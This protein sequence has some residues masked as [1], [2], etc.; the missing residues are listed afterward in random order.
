MKTFH[1]VLLMIVVGALIQY[2]FMSLLTANNMT[3]IENSLSK[4]YISLFM[5]LS[6]GVLEVIMRDMTYGSFNMNYYLP[7]IILLVVTI[8]LYRGQ[9]FIGDKQYLRDMIEHHS[10]A[11][12]TSKEILKKSHDYNVIKLAK[13]IINTQEEEIEKMKGLINT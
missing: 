12:L 2:Y 13:D 9:F 5:G 3:N 6:M 1:S 10:M 11:L 4:L 8:I 7:L